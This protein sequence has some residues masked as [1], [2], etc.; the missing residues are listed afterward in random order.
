MR[1]IIGFAI[2]A[3]FAVTAQGLTT[4]VADVAEFARVVAYM[5][6]NY[7]N[8]AHTLILKKGHYDVRG[9]NLPYWHNTNKEMTDSHANFGIS[10]FTLQGETGDPRDVVIF[11]SS[12]EG[13]DPEKSLKL[14]YNYAGWIRNLTLSNCVTTLDRAIHA[15]SSNTSCSNVIVTCCSAETYGASTSGTWYDCQ[16]IGNTAAST[17][18]G[19]T[20]AR[21]YGCIFEKNTAQYGGGAY[22]CTLSNCTFRANTATVQ[23]GGVCNGGVTNCT[24]TGNTAPKGGGAAGGYSKNLWM[25]DCTVTNNS[26][27][28]GGGV[29][30][31]LSSAYI[32]QIY[33]GTVSDNTST[34]TGGGLYGCSVSGCVVRVNVASYDGGGMYGCTARDCTI[35]E[36]T[37][38]EDGGGT[39]DSTLSGCLVADNTANGKGGGCAG[40]G[41]TKSQIGAGS[42]ISNNVCGGGGGGA[43]LS[44]IADSRIC[45]NLMSGESV[46]DYSNGGGVYECN[47]TNSTVDGNAVIKGKAKKN[48]QGGGAYGSDLTDCLICNN[49]V[50][51]LGGG[52]AAGSVVGCIISNNVCKGTGGSNALRGARAE[53]CDIYE[54][55]IDPQGPALNCR[56]MNYTNGNVIAVGANVYTNGYIPGPSQLVKSYGWFTNCLFVG[57]HM[58]TLIAHTATKHSVFSGCTFADNRFQYVSS[59]FIGPTN[60]LTLINCILARNRNKANTADLNFNPS[61]SYIAVTNCMIGSFDNLTSKALTYPMSNVITNNN[62]RFVADGSRDSYALTYNSPARGKGL[63]QDWMDGALDIRS[64]ARYPRLREGKVDI[65]C[66]ECWLE[67]AGLSVTI[68]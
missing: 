58:S 22:G 62:P 5:N 9:L 30:R 6:T 32:A 31:D 68:R 45:M 65:G 46:G 57:N 61:Y 37:S 56:F 64:D 42:V 1:K 53:N 14:V 11:R 63:A 8:S 41:K 47:V 20:N 52:V 54:G 4:N 33:G 18:G 23:G 67:P 49:Y 2:A 34:T 10:G 39:Y 27:S 3:V 55:V 60:T 28:Y 59:G 43:Y 50:D 24:I 35:A 51:S 48:T 12:V 19:L 36:N 40:S 26:A 16:F 21:A 66:Y 44:T 7:H 13:E 29:Y 25:A 15:H 38:D 17:G